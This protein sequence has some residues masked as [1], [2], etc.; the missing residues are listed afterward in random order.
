MK[1]DN[2]M[3]ARFRVKC[4]QCGQVQDINGP[5]PCKCG[6]QLAPQQGELRLYRMGNFMGAAAGFGVYID[7]QPFGHIGNRE[8]VAYSLPFGTHRIHVAQG[9]SR[10][11]NDIMVTLSPANP[12]GYLKVRIKPGFWTNSF[13]LEP[14]TPEEMPPI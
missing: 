1:G 5:V 9:M 14:S 8:T 12:F 3:N 2:F 6:A 4:P 11:C 7:E 10:K 13:V